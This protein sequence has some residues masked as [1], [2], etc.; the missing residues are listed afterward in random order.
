M[1]GTHLGNLLMP[2]RFS[3]QVKRLPVRLARQ[4]SHH[5]LPG[6]RIADKRSSR[7][8]ALPVEVFSKLT[9]GIARLAARQVV[10]DRCIL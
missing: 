4:V 2:A 5:P 8:P 1:C 9:N 3:A 7:I 10:S 6:V